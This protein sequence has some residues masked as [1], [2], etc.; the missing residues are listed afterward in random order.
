MR[1]LRHKE[2]ESLVQ[3]GLLVLEHVI[4]SKGF[5][6]LSVS[7]CYSGCLRTIHKLYIQA[8]FLLESNQSSLEDGLSTIQV[9]DGKA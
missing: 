1:K 6:P 2:T 8:G 5:L 4:A 3:G 7:L 9:V